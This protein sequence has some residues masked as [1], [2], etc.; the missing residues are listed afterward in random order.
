MIDGGTFSE[1]AKELATR[2]FKQLA[3]AEA[4]V[5]GTS[6]EKAGSCRPT[7]RL[8]GG[9]LK[10]LQAM[11]PEGHRAVV[12]VSLTDDPPMAQAFVIIEALPA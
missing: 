2:V 4:V 3:A 11:T 1:R 8:T 5:H 12:H 10:R 7:M 6:I 9:A